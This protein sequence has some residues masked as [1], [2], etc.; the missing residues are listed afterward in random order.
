MTAT[1]TQPASYCERCG[2]LFGAGAAFCRRCGSPRPTIPAGPDRAYPVVPS[3]AAPAARPKPVRLVLSV[4]LSLVTLVTILT[5]V[6]VSETPA[7]NYCHFACGTRLG[8]RLLGEAAYVSP[9]FRYRVEYEYPFRLANQSSSGV[10]MYLDADNAM[11][12]SAVPGSDVNGAIQRAIN[13]LNTNVVQDLRPLTPELAGAEIG[14]VPGS[15]EAF[16]ATFVAPGNNTTQ[17]VSV[18]VM[19]ATQANLTI[20][21]LVVGTQDLSSW[22]FLPLGLYLGEYFDFE[23]SNTLWPSQS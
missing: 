16:S 23:I 6:A 2:T 7:V 19:A 18:V 8:P 12:F 11:V 1:N 10:E 3:G 14:Y 4:V 13:G 15:G 20:S 9:E 5:V 21:V 17:A 22:Q